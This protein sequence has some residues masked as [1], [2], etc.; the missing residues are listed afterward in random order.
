MKGD[1]WLFFGR[2]TVAY[3]LVQLH[4]AGNVVRLKYWLLPY[5][6]SEVIGYFMKEWTRG[7]LKFVFHWNI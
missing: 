1:H 7:L 4:L 6:L 3:W 2:F 5:A